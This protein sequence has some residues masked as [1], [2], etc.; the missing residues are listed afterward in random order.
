MVQNVTNYN[1]GQIKSERLTKHP[2]NAGVTRSQLPHFPP[3]NVAAEIFGGLSVLKSTLPTG[4]KLERG[5]WCSNKI[6]MP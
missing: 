6:L 4:G 2:Q 3:L 1:P 5:D